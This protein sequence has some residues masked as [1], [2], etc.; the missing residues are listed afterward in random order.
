MII[1]IVTAF[2]RHILRS[3][4]QYV[5][6][7]TGLSLG[8]SVS[9]LIYIYVR[10]ETRFDA[11]H[12]DVSRIYRVHNILDM[13]GKTDRT[14]K[15][16]LNAGEA[17]QQFY[18]E[19]ESYM[20]L[21][22]VSKQTVRIGDKLYASD[23]AVYS[24]SNAFTFFTFPFLKGDPATALTGPN[25]AV[26]SQ[27]TALQYFGSVEDAFGK[28][29]E[30]NKKDFLVTG[31][32][33]DKSGRTHIPYTIFL[34]LSTLPQEFLAQRN[35]EYMWLTTY[36][37]IKL[38]PSITGIDFQKKLASFHE[39]VLVPYVKNAEVNG[40][41]KMELE[42]LRN[43]HLDNTLRFDVPGA[44]NPA[45]LKIFSAVG[46]LTL[47]IALIN[48]INL[49]TAKVSNRIKEVGIKKYLGATRKSLFFQFVFETIITSFLCFVASLVLVYLSLPKL[50]DLT[51]ATY[52]FLEVFDPEMILT[53]VFFVTC[54]GIAGSLYPA[55]L[56]TSFK[57][58]N[59]IRSYKNVFHAS[60]LENL[61][62]PA[63][64][65]KVLVTAQFSISIFLIIGTLIIFQQFQFMSS[66]DM[67]FDQEQVMVIDVPNDTTVSNHLDVLKNSLLGIPEVKSVSS[68]SSIPGSD[69]GALTMNV[70]QSGG[71]EIKVINTYT[72]DEKFQEALSIELSEGRFFSREFSTDPQ[73]AFVINEAAAKF[74]GWDDPL[75]KKIESPLGQKGVVVGVLKDF[76]YKSLHS[77]IEPLI[78]MH[79]VTSQGY[80]LVKV[81][82]NSMQETVQKV[83]TIWTDFD[84]GHPYEFF[85][86]DSQFQKQ[87]IKEQRLISI[88]AYFSAFAIFISC[89]GLIGLA[90]FTNETRV[91]EI[92]IRKTLGASKSDI[93]SLLS[94]GF[95]VPVLIATVI[96]WTISFYMVKDWLAQFAYQ[97]N[98]TFLPFLLGALIA[99]VIA[100]LTV[101]YFA[102]LAAKQDIVSSLRYE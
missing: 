83:S 70:S 91:K 45:Y 35:R 80:L 25:K 36:T 49:T 5:T 7:I 82:T 10:G 86:L 71:S 92:G 16:C 46:I 54:F 27:T 41:I 11:H 2:F 3:R 42:P 95:M 98:L 29:M 15:N 13:E 47:L 62:N 69:H 67:G 89:L 90:I 1:Q 72:V 102:R 55:V 14:A 99:L 17:L 77:S 84:R 94:R 20:Q 12:Q 57:P 18:P 24:D 37:Y 56:L 21:L 68:A 97:V 58:L 30:V 74:L 43:I 65:R 88:F 81:N 39:K 26:I 73:Q 22:N 23:K 53:S 66:L 52:G 64:V 93:I 33:D 44:V 8:M 78:L 59:A 51:G 9:I 40:S 96:A 32:Y 61:L 63:V 76:N 87:Y 79:S 48:Y 100:G 31:I 28:T 19:V 60:F 50:S 101:G 6:I 4:F 75:D 85:F 38:K 34:S